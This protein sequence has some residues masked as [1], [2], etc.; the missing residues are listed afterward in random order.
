MPTTHS[1]TI[2]IIDDMPSNLG[3]AVN[4][5]EGRGYR[6]AIAQDGEEGL[7]R[8]QLLLPDLILLD[9]MMPGADG[10]EICHRL[11]AL[12]ET[13]DIPVI[14]MTAL[15]S[16][17]D[18]VKGFA[19]GG[20]DYVTKPLQFDE[21]LARVD[22]HIKL[23]AAH[24]RLEAQHAQLRAYQEHL[25]LR[26]AERTAEL[27]VANLQLQVEI[28]ERRQV[29]LALEESRAQ[30]R[31]LAARN[32]Q[33]SEEERKFVA[34][35]LHEDLA[36]ILT[37]LQLNLAVLASQHKADHLVFNNSLQ[38]ANCLVEKA[39][40]VV[41]NIS[42]MLRPSVLDIGISAV[43]EWLAARFSA[44]TGIACRVHIHG[45]EVE[46]AESYAIGLFR[47]VQESLANVS[48]HAQADLVDITLE[49][50]SQRCLLKIRDNG[51]GFD[52]S[53]KKADALG[54]LGIQERV[55]ALGGSVFIN[56]AVGSGAEIIVGI[57]MTVV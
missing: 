50:D 41:R 17:D 51:S 52:T 53:L 5:L 38:Q 23:H 21:V 14:F 42:S 7:Q 46:L 20:V 29:E 47:I 11:K 34:H 8:A 56:S 3:M 25:E 15:A 40:G 22:T 37:G 2:L 28:E 55:L 43:L 19:A 18:K 16:T 10:F 27:S 4:L 9:V 13:C 31:S 39:I 12:K 26:V 36:Q 33:S 30:L 32:H 45:D 44:R 24:L 54:L 57:P 35:E 6:V 49:Q 1:A 48:Q